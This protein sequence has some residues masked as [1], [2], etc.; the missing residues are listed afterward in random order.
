LVI[1][2]GLKGTQKDITNPENK[3]KTWTNKQTNKNYSIERILLYR[4]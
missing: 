3:P 1:R 4:R 2:G